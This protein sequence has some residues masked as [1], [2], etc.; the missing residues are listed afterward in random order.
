MAIN[1][2]LSGRLRNTSLPKS[3]ALLPLF[4][5]VVNAIQAVDEE[6]DLDMG[7]A[8]IEVRIIRGA[9][10]WFSF[11]LDAQPAYAEPITGFIVKDN[12]VGFDD[13]N[14]ESFETL[15]SEYKSAKGCRGVGR[16]LWLKAFKKV[17]VSS[18][19]LN[20]EKDLKEREFT[21]TADL[22]VSHGSVWGARESG[23]GT[24][25][26]LLGFGEVYQ[27]HAPKNMLPI[28]KAI[29]EHCLWYF[30]RP[31]GAPNV[32]ITDGADSVDLNLLYDEY[33]LASSKAQEVTVKGHR[34]YLTHLRLKAGSRPTPEL[35]W[36]AA[37]RVVFEENLSGKVP[38]LH[39]RLKDG[40]E[41]FMYAC[42][43]ESPFLDDSVRPERTG[44]DI[45]D[46]TPE[47]TL[48]PDELS[49]AEIRAV[50]L[51]AVEHY[52]HENLAEV[53]AAG[54]ERVESFVAKKAPRYRP[55]LRR[56]GA[57]KLSVDPA[58]GDRELELQLHK[59]LADIEAELL[60][61][62]QEVLNGQNLQEEEYGEK[63]RDYLEKVDD[64]KKSD[65]AAYVS[66]R[67]VILDLL[68]KAIRADQNGRYAREN[69]IHSLIMPMRATSDDAP[70]S[71]SN[72]WVIDEGLAFHNYLASDK[73]I[74]SM[75]ITRSTSALEPDILA[76]QVHDEPVLVAQ[77]DSLPLASIVV[78]EIKRPMRNDAAPGPEKDPVSQSLRYLKQVRDG[79]VTT[80]AGRP[81][82]RSDQI[83][84]FCY[85]AADLT[86]T[87]QDRCMQA[88]LRMTP[89]GL[90]YFGYNDNYKAYIEVSSF[91]RLLNMAHQRNRAFFDRLGL[92]VD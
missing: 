72:L 65:L 22:G 83:P 68:A 77:G 86:P 89:D 49:M 43:L 19:Y 52:L 88:N 11:D 84:G 6:P 48:D 34:F 17:E 74:G 75:P 70:E 42:F 14:M 80:A 57:D 82:P 12:G 81:I 62:G 7:A 37:S 40:A 73:P 4:E 47:G 63:L 23:T 20:A 67:R 45:P 31:G 76:L 90:G 39:G 38:G 64:V 30:V 51:T 59:H 8:S 16:L 36:C 53:L 29:L 56:I 58:I 71:A 61:E 44:F 69:V 85:V 79:N 10:M 66:R 87:V 1:A 28:A 27:K 26:R 13:R 91:D 21:F 2:S 18:R 9:Q 25:V 3:R 33:M 41:E 54:R 24:E 92:P 32:V 35:N 78:V 50:A 55:I 46:I 15:D 5:A 60:E